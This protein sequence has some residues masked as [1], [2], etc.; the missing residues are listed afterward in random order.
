MLVC[1]SDK[2]ITPLAAQVPSTGQSREL[3]RNQ[4]KEGQRG[5]YTHVASSFRSLG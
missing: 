4:L 3:G 1:G 5:L 2:R